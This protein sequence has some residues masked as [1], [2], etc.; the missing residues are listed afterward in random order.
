MVRWL[1]CFVVMPR[2]F[3]LFQHNL[4]FTVVVILVMF[5]QGCIGMIKRCGVAVLEAIHLVR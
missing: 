4:G 2:G 3:V 5:L 1:C